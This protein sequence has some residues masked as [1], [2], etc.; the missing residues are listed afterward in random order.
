MFLPSPYLLPKFPPSSTFP[1][2]PFRPNIHYKYT[3]RLYIAFGSAKNWLILALAEHT[4]L[5]RKGEILI[6]FFLLAC[7]L[8]I[9]YDAESV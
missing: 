9:I 3:L 5:H 4:L 2:I 8:C 7:V 1:Y 6:F